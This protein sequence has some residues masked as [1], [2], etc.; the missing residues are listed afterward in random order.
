MNKAQEDE[1]NRLSRDQLL[2]LFWQTYGWMDVH[3]GEE[4]HKA[5]ESAMIDARKE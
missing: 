3:D 4:L 2:T 1:I 5:I